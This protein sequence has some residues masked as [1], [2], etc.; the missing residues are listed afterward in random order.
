[1]RS[2]AVR[3]VPLVQTLRAATERVMRERA[4]FAR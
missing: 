2:N 4:I 1:M 3:F